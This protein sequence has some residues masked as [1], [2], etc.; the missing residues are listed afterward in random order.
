MSE[1]FNYNCYGLTLQSQIP[2]PELQSLSVRLVDADGPEVEIRLGRLAKDGLPDGNQ[3]GPF[4]WIKATTLWLKVVNVATFLVS[5]GRR[6]IVDPHPGI[7]DDSVRAFLLGSAL[8]ALLFQRGHLVLHGNAIRIGD[9]CMICIGRSGA[10]KST[11][12]AGFMQRGYSILADDVVPVDGQCR[13][14]PGFPRIKLWRDVIE[15]LA[16]D[17]SA[18]CRVRPCTEKFNLPVEPYSSLSPLPIR[19]VYVLDSKH[20]EEMKIEPI[21]GMQGFRP[22]YNNTYRVRFLQ[23]MSLNPEHLRLCGQLAAQIRLAR[24]T[25]PREGFSLAPMIDAILADIAEHP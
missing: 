6:I 23:G 21:L 15:R 5:D 2:L 24:I 20:I 11:L 12:A 19:W 17:T 8:G 3:L 4:V 16:I 22:L 10:G 9:Q 25:R 7:D 18:L 14:L 1:F 13:A